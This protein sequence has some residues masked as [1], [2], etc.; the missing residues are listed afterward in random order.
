MKRWNILQEILLPLMAAAEG[1]VG[2]LANTQDLIQALFCPP[3]ECHGG[4]SNLPPAYFALAPL[5]GLLFS[6]H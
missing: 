3:C 4:I 1:V 5:L 6:F 2:P